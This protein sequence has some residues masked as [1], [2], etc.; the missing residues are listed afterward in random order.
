[1]SVTKG[2]ILLSQADIL[3]MLQALSID[4]VDNT[5]DAVKPISS[6]QAA[7]LALK[8]SSGVNNFNG[9]QTHTL[10]SPA[11]APTITPDGTTWSDH[12]NIG[13]LTGNLILAN[14]VGFTNAVHLRIWLTQDTVGG[15]TI[16][17]GT[18]YK[19]VGGTPIVLSTAAG[20]IDMLSLTYNP[21]KGI[22]LTTISKGIA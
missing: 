10:F 17:F 20:A 18:A 21:A 9:V 15:R 19:V 4:Q 5:P 6:Y 14:P 7:A 1:M 8:A 11:Y 2:G 13:A 12:N 22:W 3:E 16:T